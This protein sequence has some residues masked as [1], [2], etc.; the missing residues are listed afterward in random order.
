M[1]LPQLLTALSALLED[2]SILAPK[3]V[4]FDILHAEFNSLVEINN[5]ARVIDYNLPPVTSSSSNNQLIALEQRIQSLE[6]IVKNFPVPTNAPRAAVVA[7]K[8]DPIAAESQ[9]PLNLTNNPP[10]PAIKIFKE[11]APVYPTKNTS[12]YVSPPLLDLR[13]ANQV[14]LRMEK[15]QLALL[16]GTSPL[17]TGGIELQNL[18]RQVLALAPIQIINVE[19]LIDS[20]SIRISLAD[21]KQAYLLR[22][23][24]TWITAIHPNLLLATP[25]RTNLLM[26]HRIPTIISDETLSEI[27]DGKAFGLVQSIIRIRPRK[28][29]ANFGSAKVLFKKPESVISFLESVD[30]VFAGGVSLTFEKFD[31]SKKMIQCINCSSWGH[32]IE[33][34]K[35]ETRCGR[36]SKNH[37]T[38]SCSAAGVELKCLSC[39]G[40]V[41]SWHRGCPNRHSPVNPPVLTSKPTSVK[42]KEKAVPANYDITSLASPS[43][44]SP[45]A[46]APTKVKKAKSKAVLSKLQGEALQSVERNDTLQKKLVKESKEKSLRSQLYTSGEFDDSVNPS[47]NPSPSVSPTATTS[48]SLINGNTSNSVAKHQN[49]D[50]VENIVNRDEE[51][52]ESPVGNVAERVGVCSAGNEEIVGEVEVKECPKGKEQTVGKQQILSESLNNISDSSFKLYTFGE[53]DDSVDALNPSPIVSSDDSHTLITDNTP[54]FPTTELDYSSTSEVEEESSGEESEDQSCNEDKEDVQEEESGS[55]QSNIEEQEETYDSSEDENQKP[56]KNFT[57]NSL[58]SSSKV[59][60][61]VSRPPST[62]TKRSAPQST[63]EQVARSIQEKEERLK[64]YRQTS[65]EPVKEQAPLK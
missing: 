13:Y 58:A 10:V 61:I 11:L 39:E 14:M 62:R 57:P 63:Q 34:C 47:L 21:E 48:S 31:E 29:S 17:L 19:R 23:D 45:A 28:D 49:S 51:V 44:P 30:L 53:A 20:G 59:T 4:V 16:E 50:D 35:F 15:S 36:C 8:I 24:T 46:N 12:N 33:K 1:Q 38:S 52:V 41:V 65:S 37:S 7:E 64:Q 43:S 42:G 60:T 9:A 54:I 56:D 40:N 27:L 18:V 3:K 22:E 5:D 32:K 2:I 55:I 6:I 25:Y 26:V